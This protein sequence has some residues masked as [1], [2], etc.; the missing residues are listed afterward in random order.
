MSSVLLPGQPIPLPPRAPLPQLGPGA[1]SRDGIARAS[2]LGQPK[3]DGSVRVRS[4]LRP[5]FADSP[6]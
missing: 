1:Y 2:L 6:G 5:P 3:I 4:T